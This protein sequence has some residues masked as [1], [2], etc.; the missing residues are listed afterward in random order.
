[1]IMVE[2]AA[3]EVK[4]LRDAT[5][6]GMMDAKRALVDANGDHEAAAQALREQGLAKAVGRSDRDNAEGAI[7]LATTTDRAALVHLRC[8]TD[9]S[10]KS[11]GFVSLVDDL[12]SAVLEEG[13]GA[14]EARAAALDDLRLSIK[15]NVEVG[16]VALI[17]AAT[18]N[19][20][21][22]YL[23][24]Q[25]GRGVNGVVVEASGVDQEVLHQIALHIAFAKPTALS[26]D[27][28]PPD[29]V[30]VERAA[31][32]DITKA[33][34]KPEQAWDKIVEGRLSAWFRETVLLEQGLHGD[35]TTVQET[36]GEGRIVRFVQA[37]IGN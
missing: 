22:A 19:L 4:A 36:L 9:F 33:E 30:E 25:D 28:V 35:K 8:E 16:Q 29:L 23:H 24:R 10:A 18:D 27:E 7:G 17:E 31:L 34:G 20:I 11:E 6:A 12:A 3:R 2:V 5:G 32:L 13:E 26:R 37:Y 21:D 1:M 14:P 15:E